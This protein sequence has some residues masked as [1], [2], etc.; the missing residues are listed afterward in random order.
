MKK[1]L[2]CKPISM[3]LAGHNKKEAKASFLFVTFATKT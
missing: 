1:V 2:P 3:R